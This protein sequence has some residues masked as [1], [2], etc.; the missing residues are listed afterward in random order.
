MRL[1]KGQAKIIRRKPKQ[2]NS[3]EEAL[4]AILLAPRCR[5]HALRGHSSN[6]RVV[7][8]DGIGGT[9]CLLCGRLK[10]RRFSTDILDGYRSIAVGL[11]MF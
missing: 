1:E 2:C 5:S 8:V 3:V 10:I 4:L 6:P 9:E 11:A 7:G